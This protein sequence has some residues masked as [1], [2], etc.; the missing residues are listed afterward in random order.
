MDKS[1]VV[2]MNVR[3]I[4]YCSYTLNQCDDLIDNTYVLHINRGT[5]S[6]FNRSGFEPI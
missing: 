1:A 6:I 3:D 4:C 2:I 5:D